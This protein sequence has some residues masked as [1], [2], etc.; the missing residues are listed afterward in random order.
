M[1]KSRKTRNTPTSFIHIVIQIMKEIYQTYAIP[2]QQF[3]S[4]MVLSFFGVPGNNL[5]HIEAVLT[6]KQEQCTQEYYIKI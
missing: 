3:K 1:H 5:I 6:Q 4:S 2:H